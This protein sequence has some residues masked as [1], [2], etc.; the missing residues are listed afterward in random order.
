[1][2]CKNEKYKAVS[3]STLH[4]RKGSLKTSNARFNAVKL[5][6]LLLHK[7]IFRLP[8]SLKGSLKTQSNLIP[9]GQPHENHHH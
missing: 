4:H 7:Q 1:M 8:Q 3:F 6:Q 5:S 2:R 9:K